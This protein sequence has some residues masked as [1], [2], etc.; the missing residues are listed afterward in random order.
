MRGA[1]GGLLERRFLGTQAKH[2]LADQ[3]SSAYGRAQTCKPCRYD[4]VCAASTWSPCGNSSVDRS[5]GSCW[6]GWGVWR[7]SVMMNPSTSSTAPLCASGALKVYTG[8]WSPG[9]LLLSLLLRSGDCYAR[10]AD[11]THRAHPATA[12]PEAAPGIWDCDPPPFSGVANTDQPLRRRP[13]LACSMHVN[14]AAMHTQCLMAKC[15]Q[16]RI[17]VVRC[18]FCA[19]LRVRSSHQQAL[20]CTQ[21]PATLPIHLVNYREITEVNEAP[22]SALHQITNVRT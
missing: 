6:G 9:A 3:L 21:Q 4:V 15:A 22:Q 2:K 12:C 18:L 16:T 11:H 5:R 13:V 8:A 20:S 10:R 1:A 19:R 7:R 17:V 14:T